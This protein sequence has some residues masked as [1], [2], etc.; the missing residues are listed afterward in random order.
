MTSAKK[1]ENGLD[2]ANASGNAGYNSLNNQIWGENGSGYLGY[3]QQL[4]KEIEYQKQ[5]GTGNNPLTNEQLQEMAQQQGIDPQLLHQYSQNGGYVQDG[6]TGKLPGTGEEGWTNV[7]GQ[8]RPVAAG[9]SGADEQF[10][11]DGGYAMLQYYK[12]M[13]DKSTEPGEK[14]YWHAMAEQLRARAGYS[15]GAD[16]S[17]YIPLG[18][19]GITPGAA[20]SGADAEY[21]GVSSSSGSGGINGL[22][23]LD[24]SQLYALLEE[25][26]KAA[27]SQANGQ[28]DYAVTQAITELER[29][30]QDAQPQFKDQAETVDRNA[31][32]A[33]DNAALYA[34]M[35]GDSGGIGQEQY[36]SI[37]NTQAQNHL[38]V[39]QAQTKLAT[40]TQRQIADLR[41]QGEFEKADAA[42]QVTQQYLQQLISLE[43]WAAEYNLS[44]DQFNIQLQQ[45]E[46]EYEMAM[47]QFKASQDQWAAE[48]GFAQQQYQN[49]L[50]QWQQEFDYNKQLNT[51]NQAASMGE[52][53]LGVG[54]MPSEDQLAAMGMTQAQAQ[55]Y[56]NMVQ[57]ENQI[58]ASQGSKTETSAAYKDVAATAKKKGSADLTNKYLG[59]MVERGDISLEEADYIFRVI[60]GYSY[61]QLLENKYIL[62]SGVKDDTGPYTSVHV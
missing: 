18:Q 31:R 22:S 30:L 7:E 14:E 35:R 5:H 25:W 4:E 41:A 57:L 29:A 60:C 53:L 33:M 50:S 43:Q 21:G 3:Q 62:N 48:F 51:Q 61:D 26:K 46:K 56:I 11:S 24:S 40:D 27:Q 36:N 1:N 42:L 13:Y 55:Q 49:S 38:A 17:M 20:D 37:Q 2:A 54:I 19:L 45:W 23:H 59:E 15:G 16:G 32:T 58:K 44:V 6:G 10:L 12:E 8:Q 52:A 9:T 34:E 28:I 47:M 39:Q